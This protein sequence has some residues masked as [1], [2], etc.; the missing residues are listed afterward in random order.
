MGQVRVEAEIASA[1]WLD[2]GAPI[3]VK[4]GGFY[5]APFAYGVSH[6]IRVAKVKYCG[7]GH[8]EK[9]CFFGCIDGRNKRDERAKNIFAWKSSIEKIDYRWG[10]YSK[11]LEKM[12]QK[13]FTKL[14]KCAK[15]ILPSNIL[16]D[17]QLVNRA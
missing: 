1:E 17:E 10:D 3:E 11:K 13:W 6:S 5:V 14:K 12:G 2:N 16:L 8:A 7:K 15:I 9:A 4:N